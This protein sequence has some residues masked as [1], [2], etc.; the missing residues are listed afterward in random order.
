MKS[1]SQLKKDVLEE[2][3][4]E[5]SVNATHLGVEVNDGIVTLAGH[6]D[7]YA[8]KFHAERAAQRVAGVR[9][10][11]VEMDVHLPGGL[12]PRSD[13]DVARSTENA[14][15]WMTDL[16]K[17]GVKV[18]VENGWITLTG[19]V[20]HDY[21]RRDA[22]RGVRYL[23]GVTGVSDQITLTPQTISQGDVKSSIEGALHRRAKADA[24]DIVVAVDGTQVTLTGNVSS[25]SER[26][27]AKHSAW[28]TRGVQSVVDKLTVSY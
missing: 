10:L 27:L 9:A 11:A 20:D 3:K 15:E 19:E 8:E 12:S 28:S 1:D 22:T 2:L 14:L 24:K 26:E 4:W 23:L 13:A 6:V 17:G 5:P 7:S 16:P 25:W 18:T 21:Q